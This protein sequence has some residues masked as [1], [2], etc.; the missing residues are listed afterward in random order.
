[1]HVSMDFFKSKKYRRPFFEKQ[2]TSGIK[3]L[4]FFHSIKKS[5]HKQQRLFLNVNK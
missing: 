1:M 2:I 4:F 5:K 3:T